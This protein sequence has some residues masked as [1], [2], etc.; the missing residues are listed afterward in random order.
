[1]VVLMSYEYVRTYLYTLKKKERKRI[2]DDIGRCKL[3][4]GWLFFL[5]V[6]H[7]AFLAHMLLTFACFQN[8]GPIRYDRFTVA[9]LKNRK[10]PR[11]HPTVLK[12]NL[13]SC[14]STLFSFSDLFDSILSGLFWCWGTFQKEKNW[15]RI[16]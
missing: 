5:R 16:V 11:L 12:P 2:G 9:K 1:M 4:Y 15:K 8:L 7:D 13:T 10:C 14:F 3:A 6:L